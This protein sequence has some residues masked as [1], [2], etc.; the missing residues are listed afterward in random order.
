[1]IWF[2]EG[3]EAHYNPAGTVTHAYSNISLGT[4]V[5][6][7]DRTNDTTTTMEY[8]FHGLASSTLATVSTNGTINTRFNYA[9]FGEVIE[10]TDAGSPTNGIAAH[11]RRFNDKQQDD[12]SGLT[13][14]GARYYDKLLMNWT[15]S[16][17]LYLRIPDLGKQSTPRRSNL[18]AFS[19]NNPVRYMDPDGLDSKGAWSKSSSQGGFEAAM[20]KEGTGA[21]HGGVEGQSARDQAVEDFMQAGRTALAAQRK[22]EEAEILRQVQLTPT[23]P[24]SILTSLLSQLR[25]DVANDHNN[26]LIDDPELHAHMFL[27]VAGGAAGAESGGNLNSG[28]VVGGRLAQDVGVSATAPKVLPLNR[29]ISGRPAQNAAL[30]ADIAAAEL[31][32]GTQFRVNQQ[33]V[34]AAG[35][36]VGTNRPDLQ[37]TDGAG[38]RVYIEYDPTNGSRAQPHLERIRANDGLGSI[39]LKAID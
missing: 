4:A 16:D 30:Q 27:L 10:S 12:I 21:I 6:R 31:A 9:P 15:Q 18:A 3:T 14:Y 24:L 7:V 28:P 36:R 11:K 5:A 38:R 13:Y 37:Y 34:N 19:L 17:P 2:I 23:D 29:P 1:M 22:K 26:G 32:G 35:Q 25:A 8:Q 20:A 33:Q 39:T